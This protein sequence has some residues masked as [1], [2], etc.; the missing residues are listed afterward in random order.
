VSVDRSDYADQQ[1]ALLEALLR[2]GELP[3]G[4]AAANAQ[5][6]SRSLRSKRV[7]A[8]RHAW[9]ALTVA[10]GPSFDERFDAFARTTGPPAFGEGLADGLA[11]VSSLARQEQLDDNVRVEILFARAILVRD[12]RGWRPRRGL[13]VRVARLRHPQRLLFVVYVPRWGRRV[14]TVALS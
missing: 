5:A 6:A 3:E 7:G 9:P 11:F 8:L 2:G 13:F 10:L 12:R 1:S 4:F 14:A